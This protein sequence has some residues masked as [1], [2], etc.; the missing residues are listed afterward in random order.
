VLA[1]GGVLAWACALSWKVAPVTLTLGVIGGLLLLLAL[2]RGYVDLLGTSLLLLGAAYVLGLLAGRHVL[3]EAAPLVAG[4][5]LACGELAAWSLEQ[6]P[7]VPAVQRLVLARAGAVGVLVLAGMGAAA[8][9]IA[10]ASA[11]LGAGLPWT[12]AGAL[13]AVGSIAVVTR[14]ATR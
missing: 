11:P 6:R 4:G 7:R 2:W 10:V 1:Y 3:D 12:L 9:V 8:L 14:L 13:A 5:M